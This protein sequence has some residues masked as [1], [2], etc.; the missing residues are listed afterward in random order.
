MIII[1]WKWKLNWSKMSECQK[2]KHF[3]RRKWLEF[4]RVLDSEIR[5]ALHKENKRTRV[6]YVLGKCW[7]TNYSSL[8]KQSLSGVSAKAKIRKYGNISEEKK[9]LLKYV[10][11]VNLWSN[12]AAAS[13][14]ICTLYIK[15][16]HY[17]KR[18]RLWL[19]TPRSLHY[20]VSDRL[21]WDRSSLSNF[22]IQ[23]IGARHKRGSPPMR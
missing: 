18:I 20:F 1:V 3:L 4:S 14:N 22:K 9:I 16:I 8:C 10:K 7:S 15:K 12:L 19:V 2:V 11:F 13:F 23:N 17:I 5:N 21:T 6:S